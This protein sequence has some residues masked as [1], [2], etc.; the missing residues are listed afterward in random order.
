MLAVDPDEDGEDHEV[1]PRLKKKRQQ[2]KVETK[3]WQNGDVKR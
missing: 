2:P 3:G 1:S